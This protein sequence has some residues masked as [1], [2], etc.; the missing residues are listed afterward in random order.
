MQANAPKCQKMTAFY[1]FF[2]AFHD[3]ETWGQTE[4]S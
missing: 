3:S 2:I 4:E 1:C